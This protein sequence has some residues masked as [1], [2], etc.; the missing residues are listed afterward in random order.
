VMG[1]SSTCDA[2]S[3]TRTC[4]WRCATSDPGKHRGGIDA[5]QARD[6]GGAGAG[7]DSCSSTHRTRCSTPESGRLSRGASRTA[8]GI[9][10]GNAASSC[11]RLRCGARSGGKTQVHRALRRG[12]REA[13]N[14]RTAERALSPSIARKALHRRTAFSPLMKVSSS[15]C[16]VL[17][18]RT[19]WS[20]NSS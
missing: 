13:M 5:L 18:R 15:V 14:S 7:R 6:T 8:T 16:R 10:F 17:V 3:S 4:H 2:D 12:L 20:E 19:E 11:E 9:A 1:T